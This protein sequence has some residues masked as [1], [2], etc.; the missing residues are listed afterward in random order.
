MSDERAELERLRGDLSHLRER[1][2]ADTIEEESKQR[3]G[4]FERQVKAALARSK[5][6]VATGVSWAVVLADRN[7]STHSSNHQGVWT[8]PIKELPAEEKLRDSAAVLTHTPFQMRAMHQ[9]LSRFYAGQR[10]RMTQAELASALGVD[11]PALERELAPLVTKKTLSQF[12]TPEGEAGYEL[13]R[14]DLF[15]LQLS[16]A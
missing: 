5:E 1:L 4:N 2:P 6:S 15:L 16:L 7:G 13:K 14:W 11:E 8:G 9:F 12:K 3:E 10:M